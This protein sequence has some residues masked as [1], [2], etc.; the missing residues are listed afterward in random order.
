MSVSV[1]FS[2]YPKTLASIIGWPDGSKFGR[3][4]ELQLPSGLF[5]EVKTNKRC[6]PDYVSQTIGFVVVASAA[7]ELRF[8]RY[9]ETNRKEELP[10]DNC[11]RLPAEVVFI[12]SHL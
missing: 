7:N 11:A 10:H 9:A 4:R 5:H 12:L 3:P 8:G 1:S 2:V 6:R